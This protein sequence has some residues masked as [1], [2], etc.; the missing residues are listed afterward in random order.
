MKDKFLEQLPKQPK[1]EI[2]EY[3]EQNS[4]IPVPARYNTLA[5]ALES[6]EDFIIRSESPYEYHKCSGLLESYEAL[7]KTIKKAHEIEN[8]SINDITI[9][10][11]K[12]NAIIS[13]E[14]VLSL[15]IQNKITEEELWSLLYTYKDTL[16]RI[17]QFC[18]LLKLEQNE[19]EK[20]ITYSYWK[21]IKGINAS[22]IADSAIKNRYHILGG[23]FHLVIEDEKIIDSLVDGESETISSIK[24]NLENILQMYKTIRELPAFDPTHC[25]IIEF[26]I[27]EKENIYFLQYHRTQNFNASSF[28]LIREPL[29]DEIECDFVRG[30]TSKDGE[31]FNVKL[32]P[33]TF[34]AIEI[35]DK[36]GFEEY[37]G[38]GESYIDVIS[39]VRD[40]NIFN[41]HYKKYE[42][43]HREM[44]QLFQPRITLF[45]DL[46]TM[47]NSKE[48]YK[49]L[50]EV[51]DT[52]FIKLKVL[53]DGQKACVK[54]M[55]DIYRE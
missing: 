14:K 46:K 43:G 28:E 41:Q 35:D 50:Y 52:Y 31:I 12:C 13:V 7:T 5:E 33:S 1:K 45:L 9:N 15:F 23:D 30:A 25:P 32:I 42:P 6:G 27:D 21:Y 48:L 26:Q 11:T 16:K 20:S 4:S 19:F 3:V 8:P 17:K 22:I 49:Y 29:K 51:D 40:L 47:P 36:A 55:S 18:Q 44:S 10:I 54:V 24:S 37:I 2:A 38:S 53:S 34:K 39:R